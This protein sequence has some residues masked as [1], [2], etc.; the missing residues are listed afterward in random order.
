[1]RDIRRIFLSGLF[2][3]ALLTLGAATAT[4]Q[5]LKDKRATT[6]S[7]AQEQPLFSEY[8]GVRLGMSADQVRSLLGAP[9]LKADDQDYYEFSASESAQIAYDK[10]HKVVTI[11]IDYAGATAP[12][13]RNV[14]GPD[15]EEKA[16]GSLYK[17]VRYPAL[18][19]WVCY[20]RTP[21]AVA[22]VVTITIQKM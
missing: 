7:P 15:V 6:V 18:G 8:Q 1:M 14:V 3:V 12:H 4:A 16:D 20:N 21:G 10:T 9:S 13:Y 17:M 11:S 5:S 19:F 2:G 22:A